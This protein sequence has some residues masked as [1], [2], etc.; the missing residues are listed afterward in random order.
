LI[1]RDLDTPDLTVGDQIDITVNVLNHKEIPCRKRTL[2]I[3]DLVFQ[4]AVQF[5][6]E[7]A[8]RH[9]YDKFLNLASHGFIGLPRKHTPSVKAGPKPR[10]FELPTFWQQTGRPIFVAKLLSLFDSFPYGYADFWGSRSFRMSEEVKVPPLSVH[11]RLCSDLAEQIRLT[12]D[13]DSPK[14]WPIE[15]SVIPV[16]RSLRISGT[17][18]LGLFQRP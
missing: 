3:R 4:I 15:S 11:L 14:R 12:A 1:L 5:D 6:H 2:R 17:S 18:L 16:I 13:S 9:G 7:R 10:D 8:E